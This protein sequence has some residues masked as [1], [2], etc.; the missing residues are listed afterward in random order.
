MANEGGKDSLAINKK[1]KEIEEQFCMLL[2]KSTT[3]FEGLRYCT[4][5]TMFSL[6]RQWFPLLVSAGQDG[7]S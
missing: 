6:L 7:R 5:G 4:L 3:L 1:E 2:A